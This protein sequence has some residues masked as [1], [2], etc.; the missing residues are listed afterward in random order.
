MLT[1]LARRLLLVIPTLIGLSILLFVISRLLPG[2]PI[3][4]AAGPQASPAEIAALRAQFGLDQPVW[5]Q[6]LRYV[7]GLLHGDLGRSVM[8]QRPVA[9]DLLTFL[10]ATIELVVVALFLAVVI[11]VPC[12]LLAA[13]W[14]NGPF[15]YFARFLSLFSLSTPPFFSGLLLQ[16]AF[17][18]TLRLLPVSGRFSM[19]EL[20]PDPVTGFMTIDSLIAGDLNAFGNSLVYLLLPAVTLSLSPMATLI[21]VM[22]SSTLGVLQ[23]D[24]VRTARAFGLSPAKIVFKYVFKN[25]FS[26]TLTMIG[27]HF[28]WLLG[29]TVVVETV[30]DWPGIGLYATKAIVSQDFMPVV[31]VALAVGALFIAVNIVVDLL[32]FVLNPKITAE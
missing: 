10:P 12:G 24:Y 2:D 11:G 27:L 21:G 26:A 8:T 32:Y 4:L 3:A 22:R 17:G 16:I 18:M 5:V 14:R 29:G 1:F 15:D 7:T 13:V 6:Y 25:A 30:F 31:G 9:A 28:G 19:M 23:Q 20:P